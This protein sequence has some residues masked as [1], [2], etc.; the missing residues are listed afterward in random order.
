MSSHPAR[1]A[2]AAGGTGGHLFPAVALAR[3]L[4]GRGH[5]VSVLTDPRGAAFDTG[6]QVRSVPA[7]R[8]TGGLLAKLT[9]GLQLARGVLAS[10]WHLKRDRIE[11]LVGFGG[12]P[13][14]APVLA[15]KISGVPVILHEQNA[16]LGRANAR[17]A[18]Y[19]RL[20]ASSFAEVE[21]LGKHAKALTGNPVRAEAVAARN[22]PYTPSAE[23][24]PFELLVFGGS[25]GARIFS[26]VVPAACA[27]LPEGL[28]ARLRV[29]QQARPEDLDE[30]ANAYRTLG[31]QAEVA[32][33]FQDL[34]QRMATSHLVIA[35]AGASTIAEALVIGRPAV[36]VPY[37]HAMD[38]H[39]TTNARAVD[40]AGG[41]WMMPQPA[42]TPEALAGRLETLLTLPGC[43]AK[44]AATAY[45]LGR[46]DAASRL[47]EAA[48]SVLAGGQ[49]LP[50]AA[51]R[52]ITP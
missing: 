6:I 25:Q 1:I 20:I 51:L 33:F 13:S 40:N 5:Q 50:H 22:T 26:D 4:V 43:A 12:Y 32:S 37:P 14:V 29:T 21:G 11:L 35:R 18:P 10:I 39:Q 34:P 42:F 47:A 27:L 52:G 9:G 3:E 38:D 31:V 24:T 17:L 23:D 46:P 36:L 48:E 19:A 15:A 7:T 8:L 30:T 49:S 28:R 16:V 2:L 41:A 44:V 45:D